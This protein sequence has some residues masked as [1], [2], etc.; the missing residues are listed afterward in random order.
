MEKG[1]IQKKEGKNG[2]KKK[3]KTPVPLSNTGGGPTKLRKEK[4]KAKM[5][6]AVD[7]MSSTPSSGMGV[8]R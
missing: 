8:Q 5:R 7:I 6:E 1:I 3:K 4:K 2:K